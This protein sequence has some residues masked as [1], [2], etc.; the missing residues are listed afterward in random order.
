[1]EEVYEYLRVTRKQV[2]KRLQKEGLQIY[3][4]CSFLHERLLSLTQPQLTV[5]YMRTALPLAVLHRMAVIWTSIVNKLRILI[6]L[7]EQVE[8]IGCHQFDQSA[9]TSILEREFQFADQHPVV[10]RGDFLQSLV[11]WRYKTYCSTT[12]TIQP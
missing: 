11:V 7:H 1:M 6:L 10:S 12:A 2:P 9:M 8:Y 5:H 3:R 4:N